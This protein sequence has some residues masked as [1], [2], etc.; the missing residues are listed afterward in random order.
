MILSILAFLGISF[1]YSLFEKLK[2]KKGYTQ[3]LAHHLK[4]K[5]LANLF[6]WF[7]VIINSVTTLFLCIGIFQLLFNFN[8]CAFTLIFKFSAVTILILLFGQ[9]MAGDFQGAANLGIYMLLVIFGWY[10]SSIA[11]QL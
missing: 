4:N 8:S 11:I 6:W 1:G 2:D 3:F 7:L 5:K 10:L 9:R